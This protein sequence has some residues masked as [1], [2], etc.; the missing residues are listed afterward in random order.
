MS[1]LNSDEQNKL[2]NSLIKL[3]KGLIFNST[4]DR[5][6]GEFTFQAEPYY[7]GRFDNND[8]VKISRDV[9][10]SMKHYFQHWSSHGQY[11]NKF[12]IPY[13]ERKVYNMPISTLNIIHVNDFRDNNDIML[14]YASGI[15]NFI[16]DIKFL[17]QFNIYPGL[18][19]GFIKKS[20]FDNNPKVEYDEDDNDQ[21]PLVYP[22]E[23][24]G[25]INHANNYTGET[26]YF[27]SL[28]NKFAGFLF[29]GDNTLDNIDEIIEI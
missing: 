13:Q 1:I 7:F 22:D 14:G 17:H 20:V 2:N 18:N 6:G 16:N 4:E 23:N 11:F 10:H 3:V 8:I 29:I 28:H 25:I 5:K 24:E 12:D 15:E 26:L 21:E 9:E 19:Y 27:L